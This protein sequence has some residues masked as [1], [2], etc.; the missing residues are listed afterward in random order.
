MA[1]APVTGGGSA[2][3]VR[4]EGEALA[5]TGPLECAAVAGLWTAALPLLE[6]A[7]VIDLGAVPHVD[8]AGLALLAE[9]QARAGHRL[10]VRGEPDGLPGL[11]AAYRLDDALQPA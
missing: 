2:A 8:S 4:R 5:F 7:K 1:H 9:L 11:R 3:R 10:V 6:G